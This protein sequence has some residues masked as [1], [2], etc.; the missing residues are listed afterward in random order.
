MPMQSG[1]RLAIV[2]L[3][4]LALILFGCLQS[5]GQAVA[6]YPNLR[7]SDDFSSASIDTSK[8]TKVDEGTTSAPSSWSIVSGE[9]KQSSNIYSGNVDDSHTALLRGTYQLSTASF[10][11]YDLGVRIR[12]SDDDIV[13][14]LFNYQ[15]PNNYYR[16]AM[17]ADNTNGKWRALSKVQ[18]GVVTTLASDTVGYSPNTNYDINIESYNGRIVISVNNSTLFDFSDSTFASGKIALYS[19][20]NQGAFFDN[21][22]V[23]SESGALACTE[24]WTCT[25]W[26]ACS[27][28]TQSRTC[29]DENNCP[30]PTSKP[31]ESQ[32]CTVSTPITAWIVGDLE[33]I[34]PSAAPYTSSRFWDGSK[35]TLKGAKNEYAAF[36]IILTPTQNISGVTV[37]VNDLTGPG[38]I[39]NSN[40]EL[41]KEH[42]QNV[43]TTD[44]SPGNLPV[45]EYP[46]PLIPF[47][48][49]AAPFNVTANRNQ[50]VWVDVYIPKGTAA[51]TYNGTITVSGSG[52]SDQTIPL[53]L[54]V[55][56]FELSDDSHLKAFGLLYGGSYFNANGELQNLSGP[57]GMTS[58]KWGYLAPYKQMA[59]QHRLELFAVS[60]TESPPCTFDSSGNLTSCTWTTYWEIYFGKHLDGSIFTSG[61][62]AGTV[63]Q[64]WWIQPPADWLA[65]TPYNANAIKSFYAEF[66]SH[67]N[68]YLN[69]KGISQRPI[70]AVSIID[71]PTSSTEYSTIQ[72][73]AS[74]VQQSVGD[75]VKIY[76]AS[77]S[78]VPTTLIGYADAWSPAAADYC[79]SNI[80]TRQ[81]AGDLGF[82][83]HENEPYIGN[84]V[85]NA[86]GI[87]MAV[88][89]LMA[90][91]Y[92]VDGTY[93]WAVDYWDYSPAQSNAFDGP[94]SRQG[95][96]RWGNGVL[97]YPGTRLNQVSGMTSSP[98]P[99]PSFR[100]KAFRSG[101]QDYEYAWMLQQQG[102]N[103]DTFVNNV[104]TRGL[105]NGTSGQGAWSHNADDFYTM[106][107][108]M[109]ALIAPSTPGNT[110]P[111]ASLTSSTSSG[112]A[113]LTVSFT[114]TCADADGTS[115]GTFH[116][117][118]CLLNFGDNTSHTFSGKTG[119]TV[120]KT[121]NASGTYNAVLT[122][123]DNS[124]A[125]GTASRS[126]SV[127]QGSCN[128][129]KANTY[130]VAL[131]SS[132]AGTSCV[133]IFNSHP[134][135][136]I[137]TD[138]DSPGKARL[139]LLKCKAGI[140]PGCTATS[141][142]TSFKTYVDSGT[143]SADI[144]AKAL[145]FQVTGNASYCS[146]AI[147]G[148]DAKNVYDSGTLGGT[149]TTTLLVSANVSE[150]WPSTGWEN[151]FVNVY[152]NN[153]VYTAE[154]SSGGG[155]SLTLSTAFPAA[156]TTG[157]F[158]I[159]DKISTS[160]NN[161]GNDRQEV[162]KVFD[163]CYAAL[164]EAQKRDLVFWA[165][166]RAN[167]VDD[168]D[169]TY[170]NAT[171]KNI[172]GHLI[173][174]S[175]YGESYSNA[176]SWIEWGEHRKTKTLPT[177]TTPY[178]GNLGG[179]QLHGGEGYGGANTVYL[180]DYLEGTRT[181][182]G[183]DA[184]AD[185]GNYWRER[186][187]YSIYQLVPQ[188]N[189]FDY[190]RTGKNV[191]QNYY[192]NYFANLLRLSNAYSI[193]DSG[194]YAQWIMQSHLFAGL[195][196]RTDLF[197]YYNPNIASKNTNLLA[198]Q[199]YANEGFFSRGDSSES[200][201]KWFVRSDWGSAPN[202]TPRVVL[203]V[204][205]G[206]KAGG[207]SD[208]G[209]EGFEQGNF[210]LYYMG[211]PLITKEYGTS[212]DHYLFR[213][214]QSNT[215]TV[216]RP[217][218]A[219]F[220]NAQNAGHAWNFNDGGQRLPNKSQSL[221]NEYLN[222]IYNQSTPIAKE[223]KTSYEYYG[224]DITNAYENSQWTTLYGTLSN[225]S[226]KVSKVQREFVYLRPGSDLKDFILVF[227]RVHS[228][229]NNYTKKA[230]F[231][232]TS[233]PTLL[234]GSSAASPATDSSTQ[235]KGHF[236]SG[237]V[238]TF[239][240]DTIVSTN[241][242]AKLFI[243]AVLPQQKVV[244]RVGG[245]GYEGYVDNPCT[246]C[247]GDEYFDSD[248]RSGVWRS[249][250]I[251]SEDKLQETFLHVLHPTD[252]STTS[253]P[254]VSLVQS[255]SG[256]ALQ[257]AIVN[258]NKAVLFAKDGI[259]NASSTFALNG[260]DASTQVLLVNLKPNTL[261]NV[262]V[263]ITTVQKVSSSQGTIC[264]FTN[265]PIGSCS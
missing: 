113:P 154:I 255:S 247:S 134:R 71:E 10:S 219:V 1:F 236:V 22:L 64:F 28:G 221:G 192:F 27:G 217:G 33:K 69:S 29:T 220:D 83:Y 11:N 141:D 157:T 40:I 42:F 151:R 51:G 61:P 133:Y 110:A 94:I 139:D 244:R 264:F 73:Y 43:T 114:A 186:T 160:F 5:T 261:F 49:G 15:D 234:N 218:E 173:G 159:F 168:Q 39:S 257:G 38:T 253:M 158:K 249:E 155:N 182:S 148:F 34:Q 205:M 137:S 176:K 229:S 115:T 162:A 26:S 150:N 54:Q 194:K 17:R 203:G 209:Q 156:P 32:S 45:G 87:S 175:F 63:P 216:F 78:C 97:F 30:N 169:T 104:I 204:E 226:P 8:W 200:S 23:F 82:F 214:I 222:A 37:A 80:Q 89:P 145:A 185:Y 116:L 55:Y 127:L 6:T 2:A 90:W 189:S 77:H 184:F 259:V 174:W 239:N 193:E 79:V 92:K 136:F 103:S 181:A 66:V 67:A 86:P 131:D 195:G 135:L 242:S 100:L 251:A 258:N 59:R 106:R 172:R 96:S 260:V 68:S 231:R 248:H 19:W 50:P 47:S 16:F 250:T 107:E 58:T 9:L 240:A 93:F 132:L 123:K 46:D 163:W 74:L 65:D 4:A 105:G 53:Q 254:L 256:V 206:D 187:L 76:V 91:K 215:L 198:L 125:I 126:I 21:V 265:N 36:Q 31:A 177:F 178:G 109:A 197:L 228:I 108:G 18:N 202:Y 245:T 207:A 121:Y 142:W 227:D 111:T 201:G 3:L 48:K 161:Y 146:Q 233:Q 191:Y 211:T 238:E 124:N 70:F 140:T 147:S 20:G 62:G 183:K 223:S 24:N 52:I 188:G 171:F 60:G 119:G 41:F 235:D 12:S 25:A 152:A 237:K 122:A 153:N 129:G 224:A 180:L 56:N 101:M 262:Q 14:I 128:D 243:K 102:G 143:S 210:S 190:F 120:S 212:S 230:L 85:V 84:H 170:F 144:V 164:S 246:L 167:Q 57:G 165:E 13:G 7:L 232:F 117:S 263:G 199:Y 179:T 35:V 44:G 88:W 149:S 138:P 112:T 196:D 81:A 99:V 118:S 241:G 98:G 95:D 208:N 225:F 213:T 130:G 72:R 75:Q 252:S 166:Q